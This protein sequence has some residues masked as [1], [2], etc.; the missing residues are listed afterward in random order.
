MRLVSVPTTAIS[1][2]DL[3][4][5][6]DVF[7]NV[8]GRVGLNSPTL[9][10]LLRYSS[11][12][13]VA[14]VTY[15]VLLVVCHDLVGLSEM[16]S[17]LIAVC[18]SSIPNYLINRYWTW[19]QTGR[20]RFWG[21]VVPFWVM[22]ILGFI[23]SVIFVAW[24]EDRSDASWAVIAANLSAFGVLWIAKFLVLDRLMWR[25]VHELQPDLDL[26]PEPQN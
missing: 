19:E 24:V 15:V 23:L 21:E 22:A 14:V 18:L 17:H 11:A 12:S 26:E 5:I 16:G 25:V 7:E 13:V 20:N 9:L 2:S 10:K 3:M 1:V 8:L 6:D 4:R